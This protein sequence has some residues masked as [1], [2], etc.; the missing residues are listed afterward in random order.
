VRLSLL[1]RLL[2]TEVGAS[3][4][5]GLG[6]FTT[7]LVMNHVFGLARLAIGQG[8]PA[9]VAFELFVYKIPY[10]VAFSI[11]MGVLLANVLGIG[12][13]TDHHEIAALRVCGTSLYR[14]AAPLV[15]GGFVVA[16]GTVVFTEGVVS[17]AN[18]RYRAVLNRVLARAPELQPVENLF[19]EGPGPEGTALYHARRYVPR[20]RT[21]EG[22]TVVYLVQGQALRIIQAHDATYHQ[23]G[24]WTFHDGGIYIIAEGRVVTT[25]FAALDLNVPRSPQELTLPPKQPSDMS[26]RELTREIG[27]SR[28]RRADPHPYVAEFHSR[29]ATAAS[30]IV[31]A[32]VAFPLSLRPHRSG[33]S[34]G[35]GLSI[36]VLFAYYAVAVP[37]QL[38]S[39]GR[40]LPPVFAAWLPDAIVGALGGVLL[41]RAAR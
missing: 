6:F 34:I 37:A 40:V 3:F 28:Q 24:A 35:M 16:V 27:A 2:F 22:V 4:A 18:D 20:T 5:F 29:L 14:I 36:L 11:P 21:L 41:V 32:L 9:G 17:A 25:K 8:I 10:L 7:L 13:L 23:G 19:F 26:L 15:L 12:R 33:P 39:D 38:A 30:S 1:D 31:F